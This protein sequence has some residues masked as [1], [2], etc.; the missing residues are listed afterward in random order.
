[1]TRT[2]TLSDREPGFTCAQ[3]AD[4]WT[5]VLG[6]PVTERTVRRM[7]RDG[8]LP[9]YQP[10][11][12]NGR[13]VI[14]QQSLTDAVCRHLGLPDDDYDEDQ[15]ST[16]ES[17]Q[18]ADRRE[19]RG[20][21]IMRAAAIEASTNWS[22]VRVLERLY[23]EAADTVDSGTGDG[24]QLVGADGTPNAAFSVAIERLRPKYVAET[25]RNS[26]IGAWV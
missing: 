25:A 16:A 7:V 2:T 8:R 26:R 3:V 9:G 6:E 1:M 24:S 22:D 13:I 18:E 12:P 17:L 15:R 19:R 21:A 11:G 10:N 20:D 14:T 4:Y 23:F 5:N